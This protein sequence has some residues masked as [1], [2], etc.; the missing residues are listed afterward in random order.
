M[1]PLKFLIIV[2][3][4]HLPM[5]YVYSNTMWNKGHYQF[6]PLFFGA[7]A[8]L[9]YDRLAKRKNEAGPGWLVYGLLALNLV[10]LFMAIAVYTPVLVIPAVTLLLCALILDRYGMSGLWAALPAV[11]ILYIVMKLPTGRDLILINQMQFLASQLASWI[12]DAFGVV[13]FREGVILITEKKQFFTEE[14]CSGI[15]SLFSTVAAIS[16]YGLMRH[17]SI[18][19]QIF[20]VLQS[21]VWVIVGNSIRVA[22]VVYLADNGYEKFS[23]GPTHE[24]FGLLIFVGIFGLTL[25]VDRALNLFLPHKDEVPPEESEIEGSVVAKKDGSNLRPAFVTWGLIGVYLLIFLFSA[26]LSYAK[27]NNFDRVEFKSKEMIAVEESALPPAVEGWRL[28]SYEPKL[29][30]E[31]SLFAPESFIWTYERSGMTAIISLDSPYGEF[32]DLTL[33]YQGLGWGVNAHHEYEENSTTG[34]SWLELS[35]PEEY[36]RVYFAAYSRD[37]KLARPANE[38]SP[39]T[40]L[41]RN[42]DLALGR[43]EA[44]EVDVNRNDEPLPISQIQLLVSSGQPLSDADVQHCRNLFELAREQLLKSARFR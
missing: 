29:R 10:V 41:I 30:S 42:I 28:T 13:H 9:L 18:G 23:H 5:M 17:Y 2:T 14:A 25:S 26:R 19:R 32:H 12:L 34:V 20:N 7:V 24:M 39:Q 35:K 8:W 16:I 40:R 27:R 33:C 3:L 31:E 15:R 11:L 21:I 1:F 44:P 43:L 6:F 37:G 36:G 22:A 4:A 38:F